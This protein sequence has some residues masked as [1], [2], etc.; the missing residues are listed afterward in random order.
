[1][2]LRVGLNL[3]NDDRAFHARVYSAAVFVSSRCC[4]RA[5]KG[6]ARDKI[7][8]IPKYSGDIVDRVI[9]LSSVFPYNGIA[10][11]DCD[12]LR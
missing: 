3:A 2:L 10:G 1:M 5:A 7:A 12:D 6:C 4:K 8:G 9:T 11:I